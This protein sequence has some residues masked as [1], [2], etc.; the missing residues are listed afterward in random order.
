MK[1]RSLSVLGIFAAVIG[2]ILIICFNSIKISGVIIVGGI[3][4]VCVGLVNLIFYTSVTR[5]ES[6]MSK[7][8][9]FVT[10]AAAIVLGICMLVFQTVFA[11]LITFMFGLFVAI[12]ALWQFFVLAVGARPYQLPAWLYTFPILLIVGSVYIFFRRSAH[13][14]TLLMLATGISLAVLGLGCIIEGSALGIARRSD[15]KAR[16]QA[17]ATQAQAQAPSQ[18]VDVTP[19]DVTHTS[20]AIAAGTEHTA[21]EAT[22]KAIAKTPVETT[23]DLDDEIKDPS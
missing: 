20:P 19:T 7:V 14:D 3:L 11:P 5:Q 10:N 9:T 4:F 23:D 16:R 13:E 6:G 21:P 15:A 12:C 8:L 17:A 22:Q 2:A 18:P 1:G